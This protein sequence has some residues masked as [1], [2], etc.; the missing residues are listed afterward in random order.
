MPKE[1]QPYPALEQ[2][3][4][5]PLQVSPRHP[6]TLL[7]IKGCSCPRP[8]LKRD[9]EGGCS[10]NSP[11][12]WVG[13]YL[14]DLYLPRLTPGWSTWSAGAALLYYSAQTPLLNLSEAK[15][16]LLQ[17]YMVLFRVWN[18]TINQQAGSGNGKHEWKWHFSHVWSGWGREG[19]R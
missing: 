2:P 5:V 19:A 17:C 15:D 14:G 10:Y 9:D 13:N 11:L 12:G 16:G 4:V 18:R 6:D 7:P 1:L 3:R 8:M